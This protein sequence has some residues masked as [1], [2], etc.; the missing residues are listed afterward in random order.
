MS[1]PL[2]CATVVER[3]HES[4][5]EVALRAARRAD[6]VEIRLDALRDP[7]PERLVTDAPRPLVLTCRAARDGGYFEG[8]EEER[9]DLLRRA[10]SAGADW[11]DVEVTAADRL[12]DRG[13]TKVIVSHHDHEATPEDLDEILE[14]IWHQSPDVAKVVTTANGPEDVIRVIRLLRDATGPVA[15]HTMG[16]AGLA[17]RILAARFG[18]TIVYGAARGG[19]PGAPGQPT[20]EELREEYALDRDLAGA[21]VLVLFGG[22]LTHSVS[23]R[24]MNRTFRAEGI[25]AIYVPWALMDPGP[26][27]EAA[28]D[29]DL[30]GAAV[31]IPLKRR[32]MDHL[33]GLEPPAEKV[34]AVNT[35]VP[36]PAGLRGTNTDLD[37]ALG[38]IREA[39]P[40]LE[41]RRALVLG[42]GGAGRAI[43]HGLADAGARLTVVDPVR[44]RARRLAEEVGGAEAT[45]EE[46]DP[47][48]VDLVVNATPV[49]QWPG[50]DESPLSA[51]FL[52]P[53]Q[54]VMDAVYNPRVTRLLADAREAGCRTVPGIE[55]LVRQGARQLEIWLGRPAPLS[56]LREEGYAALAARL[57]P[58]L[59]IGMRGAGKTTVGEIL[60]ARL[61]RPFRDLDRIIEDCAGRTIPEIFTEDGEP[62]FR[63]LELAALRTELARDGAVL[64]VGGGALD[65]EEARRAVADR[66]PRVVLLSA[67]ASVLAERIRDSGRPS[68]TGR[69]PEEE[70]A[71][72]LGRREPHYRE[73]AEITV[74]TASGTPEEAA[75]RALSDLSS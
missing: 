12:G 58:I 7:D 11:V 2:L 55:M 36:T 57:R 16:E 13:G 40:E 20:L 66:A 4:A 22:S 51:A 47:D 70:V 3:T 1:R 67:P 74:D 45:L 56:R 65:A 52:R 59:V 31:T 9:L 35:V 72:L 6:L 69:P 24:M 26:V 53:G 19:A 71:E 60:A 23:P 8:P 29:L 37:G 18:S 39:L 10:I 75:E 17:G 44:D 38:A 49:G 62:R 21:R 30:A 5:L 73:V 42:A 54:V 61:G 32:V 33:A 14:R 68:L 15:A 63:E 64:A 28:A 27:L 46:V 48:A 34:G 43:A 25:P 41:G 50:D